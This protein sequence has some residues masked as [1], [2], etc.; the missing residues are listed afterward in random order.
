MNVT[1][2]RE[3]MTIGMTIKVP[4]LV[5]THTNQL[6][7]FP[8]TAKSTSTDITFEGGQCYHMVAKN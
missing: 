8:T 3:M 5:S 6:N 1:Q 4:R 7:K 2:Q